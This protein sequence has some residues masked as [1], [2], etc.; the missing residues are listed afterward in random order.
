MEHQQ[1]AE[2]KELTFTSLWYMVNNMKI[3]VEY[4]RVVYRSQDPQTQTYANTS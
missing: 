3:R 2:G 4:K 1:T